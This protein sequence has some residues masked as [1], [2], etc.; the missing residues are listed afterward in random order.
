M[1]WVWMRFDQPIFKQQVELLLC[2]LACHTHALANL[3][4]CQR[5]AS[6]G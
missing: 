4:R 6:K 2:P 3:R 5:C 1:R